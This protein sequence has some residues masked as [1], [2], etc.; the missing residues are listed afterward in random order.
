MKMDIG[1]RN[2]M[3]QITFTCLILISMTIS[4]VLV[5]EAQEKS[6]AKKNVN[7]L[8]PAKFLEKLYKAERQNRPETN[9]SNDYKR[10]WELIQRGEYDKAFESVQ[11]I[12]ANRRSRFLGAVTEDNHPAINHVV[13]LLARKGQLDHALKAAS[14]NKVY[15]LEDGRR[16]LD[17]E[18]SKARQ[19]QTCCYVAYFFAKSGD[20]T[21]AFKAITES[22]EVARG[23]E[24]RYS[25]E[26]TLDNASVLNQIGKIDQAMQMVRLVMAKVASSTKEE[27]DKEKG[28]GRFLIGKLILNLAK[29]NHWEKAKEIASQQETDLLANLALALFKSGQAE[30]SLRVLAQYYKILLEETKD[31][32]K[33]NH[34]LSL[35]I[36]KGF[37]LL[38]NSHGN[39][40]AIA[41]AYLTEK[42]FGVVK[43][44]NPNEAKDNA[45]LVC[46]SFAYAG[47]YDKAKS[48]SL[49]LDKAIPVTA[50]LKDLAAIQLE[51]GHK[52]LAT[53]TLTEIQNIL[54]GKTKIKAPG[55]DVKFTRLLQLAELFNANGANDQAANLIRKAEA[56]LPTIKTTLA[57]R[58]KTPTPKQG[59][60]LA[61]SLPKQRFGEIFVQS[62]YDALSGLAVA[63]AHVGDHDQAINFAGQ[64]TTKYTQVSILSNTA[65]FYL[66]SG[67]KELALKTLKT[68]SRVVLDNQKEFDS[69]L[70]NPAA[71][72]VFGGMG[73][74][75]LSAGGREAYSAFV[76]QIENG[77]YRKKWMLEFEQDIERQ[78]NPRDKKQIAQKVVKQITEYFET[79]NKELAH[80]VFLAREPN[81]LFSKGVSPV[82]SAV[83]LS[84]GNDEPDPKLDECG[85]FIYL[86]AAHLEL[87]ENAEALK[88]NK[89]AAKI[90]EEIN[91]PDSRNT[92]LL[93]VSEAYYL[94][95]DPD[96]GARIFGRILD[97]YEKPAGDKDE[98]LR[99]LT[100]E[101]RRHYRMDEMTEWIGFWFMFA[102][103]DPRSS[104]GKQPD[105]PPELQ[106]AVDD[107]LDS[108]RTFGFEQKV[109]YIEKYMADVDGLIPPLKK[110]FS[111]EEAK[112][113]NRFLRMLSKNKNE[114]PKSDKWQNAEFPRGLNG[115]WYGPRGGWNYGITG[116]KTIRWNNRFFKIART[117]FDGNVYKVI[118]KLNGRYFTFF[119]SDVEKNRMRASGVL[120]GKTPKG[121]YAGFASIKEAAQAK[122]NTFKSLTKNNSN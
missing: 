49:G 44:R 58:N 57:A 1:I 12:K 22:L 69:M 73:S 109:Q 110:S 118:C 56:S 82:L 117:E 55:V 5:T 90:V 120:N 93:T 79:G 107:P 31:N 17:K 92:F 30:E 50:C 21:N 96:E 9:Y 34:N 61:T 8:S 115:K 64:G 25:L 27:N 122:P 81:Q 28:H 70:K 77:Q 97:H 52:E 88:A 54:S 105:N 68:V 51:N 63:W 19:A 3:N 43:P 6:Q 111:P 86:T 16:R 101:Q 37:D 67:N 53:A 103:R 32:R 84:F 102:A 66:Q 72:S 26:I 46:K 48:V 85:A 95:G 36:S 38:K 89:R 119:F 10:S 62:Y 7:D 104:F 45:I 23:L 42:M 108:L 24:D 71:P 20:K 87:K 116:S 76:S 78:G 99:S 65:S 75:M 98:R 94:L 83:T 59:P 41:I 91:D 4:I 11:L 39:E 2:A 15:A 80:E 60:P 74:Q 14:L 112:Q 35:I 121:N 18:R 40:D 33:N 106:Q 100:P 47:E 13:Y 114:K 29:L 113:A